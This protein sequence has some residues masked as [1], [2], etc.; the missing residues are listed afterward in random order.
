MEAPESTSKRLHP[1]PTHPHPSPDIVPI[2]TLFYAA[3]EWLAGQ[4]K[5]EPGAPN[6]GPTRTGTLVVVTTR[7]LTRVTD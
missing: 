6:P 5:L 7:V 4:L 3:N 2:L 1:S